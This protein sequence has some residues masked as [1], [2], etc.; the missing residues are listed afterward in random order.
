[1]PRSHPVYCSETYTAVLKPFHGWFTSKA[2]G[3]MM[4]SCPSREA[5]TTTFGFETWRCQK[6]HGQVC[7]ASRPLITTMQAVIDAHGCD[8]PDKV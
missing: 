5:L 6:G 4:G 1:M 7:R 3:M 8:F 2:A